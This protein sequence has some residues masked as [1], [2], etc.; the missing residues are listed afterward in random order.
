MFP[1]VRMPA[2]GSWLPHEL[3]PAW[4]LV[5]W[6]GI[7]AAGCLARTSV[8]SWS[9]RAVMSRRS[10]AGLSCSYWSRRRNDED[11]VWSRSA[12]PAG[13]PVERS[14]SA[15]RY[16]NTRRSL[17][18]TPPDLRRSRPGGRRVEVGVDLQHQG[19]EFGA[20]GHRI[21]AGCAGSVVLYP[22]GAQIEGDLGVVVGDHPAR[23]HGDDRRDG[24]AAGDMSRQCRRATDG[25]R[26]PGRGTS[27]RVNAGH[28]AGGSCGPGGMG[29]TGY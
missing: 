7:R 20:L 10:W 3:M 14:S 24:H 26:V 6:T 16:R 9:C 27:T 13:V 15:S 17:S 2:Y 29:Q 22:F 8:R 19:V 28:V 4:Q 11:H 21:Q 12:R 25:S 5:F 23:E 18:G 1:H